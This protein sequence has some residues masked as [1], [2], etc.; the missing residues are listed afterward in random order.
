ME[1]N[2]AFIF[3]RK[4][5]AKIFGIST[6][7]LSK[8]VHKG[9]PVEGK[10][11]RELQLYLPDVVA[12][13]LDRVTDNVE[14]LDLQKER[15]RLA[16]EQADKTAMENEERRGNLVDVTKI[17]PLWANLAASIKTKFLSIPTKAAPLVMGC[18]T[19]PETKEALE[20]LIHDTLRDLSAT[21]P[22]IIAAGDSAESNEAAPKVDSK[23]VGGR[24]KK[25]QPRK[26]RR[27]RAVAD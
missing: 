3:N 10:K 15:A 21:A 11:G 7:S 6:E 2:Q 4:D 14:A 23:R 18:K 20:H 25:A 8:W 19:L 22:G 9:C 27:T 24:K 1:K 26:Q 13:R 12:W 5:T 17:A 16:K